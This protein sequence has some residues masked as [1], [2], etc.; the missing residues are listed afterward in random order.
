MK[1]FFKI[2]IGLIILLLVKNIYAQPPQQQTPEKMAKME[3]EQVK[4]EVALTDSQAVLYE[5]IA[6]KYANMRG[7]FR[8]IPR[9]SMELFRKKM[10]EL[11]ERKTGEVKQILSPGQFEKYEKWMEERRKRM[12]RGRRGD[13][14]P[15]PQ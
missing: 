14:P 5:N 9:D 8:N 15:N 3:T 11:M 13:T 4:S 1:T 6:F 2:F 12:D 10:E 7:E